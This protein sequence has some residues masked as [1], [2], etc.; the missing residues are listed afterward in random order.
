M[1]FKIETYG[2]ELKG[3]FE[4][5]TYIMTEEEKRM[6]KSGELSVFQTTSY[7]Y[8]FKLGRT[9]VVTSDPIVINM[10]T[11]V[12]HIDIFYDIEDD[13]GMNQTVYLKNGKKVWTRSRDHKRVSN[14]E[15]LGIKI[16]KSE[17][18]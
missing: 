16:N 13:Y 9:K 15:K 5:D 6:E 7:T 10:T 11:Q 18:W 14:W 3:R 2:I 4:G 8:S 12:D 17:G 1:N